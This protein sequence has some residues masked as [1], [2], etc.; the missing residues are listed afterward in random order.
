MK[1]EF[2]EMTYGCP[3][4]LGMEECYLRDILQFGKVCP[5]VQ[6]CFGV[7]VNINPDVFLTGV[8]ASKGR[9]F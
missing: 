7:A 6:G 9:A 2:I 1:H 3:R 8:K 4:P 5:R